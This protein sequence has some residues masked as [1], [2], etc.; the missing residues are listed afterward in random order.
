MQ[1][2]I[3]LGLLMLLAQTV[4]IGAPLSIADV[5]QAPTLAPYSPPSFSPDNQLLAYVVTDNARRQRSV[6]DKQ[7]MQAGLAWYAIAADIWI[8]ELGSGE[9]R[10]LTNGGHN[11]APAWSPDGRQLAFLADRSGSES[12]GPARL[13]VWERSSG[14]LRQASEADVRDP[15][16]AMQWTADGHSLLVTTFVEHRSETALQ[17]RGPKRR[18]PA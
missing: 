4:A 12:V 11:W 15:L 18:P 9:A 14:K 1:R 8:T 13:W 16:T 5:L 3:T 6:D 2:H 17:R 7:I 10:N